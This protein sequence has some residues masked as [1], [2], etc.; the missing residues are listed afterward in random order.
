MSLRVIRDGRE[1]IAHLDV[2]VTPLAR[3]RGLLG[4]R[5]L[6]PGHGLQLSPCRSIHTCGMRFTIDVIFLDRDQTVLRIA[7]AVKP[8]RFRHGGRGAHSVIEVA[9]GWL[10]GQALRPGDRLAFQTR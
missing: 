5:G 4:C 2:A 10:S 7:R 9:S 1:L 8:F 6:A 3:M